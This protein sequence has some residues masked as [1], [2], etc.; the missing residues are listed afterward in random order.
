[1]RIRN[2]LMGLT[3]ATASNIAVAALCCIEGAVSMSGGVNLYNNTLVNRSDYTQRN[4]LTFPWATVTSWGT[5]GTFAGTD[6]SSVTMS[7]LIFDP[8]FTAGNPL[9]SFTKSN[10]KYSFTLTNLSQD[11]VSPTNLNLSGTDILKVSGHEDA[12]GVWTFA[13]TG[14]YFGFLF[15]SATAVSEPGIFILLGIGL[16]A[17]GVS[18]RAL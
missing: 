9:W 10:V 15:G 3:L 2:V 11:F 4:R 12:E 17:L 16:I 6:G 1:M 18:R 8:L 13:S 14:S 5:T 7:S